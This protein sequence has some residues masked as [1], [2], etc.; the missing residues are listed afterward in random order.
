[1]NHL[2]FSSLFP[3]KL[4]LVQMAAALGCVAQ[5]HADDHM[6]GDIEEIVVVGTTPM[7]GVGINADL[8]PS[9]VQRVSAKDLE[10]SQA[11]SLAEHLRYNL[12]SVTINEA[13]NNA[14]QPDVQYRGFTA[15]PLLGLPQGMSLYLNGV[16]FNEPFGDTVNWDLL[17]TDAIASMDL[18]SGSNP[19]F[20]QNTLGGALAVKLK[21]GFSYSGNEVELGAGQFGYRQMQLQSGRSFAM[22]E[23]SDEQWGYYVIANKEEED[24]WRDS[25]GSEI[26]Q[27]LSVLSWKNAE[28]QV[29]FTALLDD[30]QMIGNGAVPMA[31]M[32]IEGREAIYTHP[33]QTENRLNYFAID[34]EHW[35]SDT[36]QIA[37]NVYVRSNTTNTL[38]GDDSDYEECDVGAFET[39]CEG[40]EGEEED[41]GGAEMEGELEPVHFLGYDEDETLDEI[42]DATGQDLEAD[43]LDGTVNTSK[44][45]Q[46]SMGFALQASVSDYLAGY[47]NLMVV[48]VSM[49]RADIEFRSRTEFAELRN[50]NPGDDRGA[51]GVGLYDAESEVQ[52]DTEVQNIGVFFTDTI[53]LDDQL[54]VT[55]GG[56]YSKTDVE[57]KDLIEEGEGSLNGDHT[58]S[59]F[60]PMAGATYAFDD[61]MT[62]YAS[63]SEASRAPTPAELSC[64]DED[65][66]CKLP[67]GFVSDPPLE[68][69]VTKSIEAGLRGQL[70]SD[71]SEWRWHAGVFRSINHDDILFQQ[72]GGLPSEGYFANVG[73]TKRLGTELTLSGG[74]DAVRVAAAYTWMKATFETPFISF[75]PNNPMGANRQVEKGDNIPGLPDHILKLAADW[76]VMNQVSIGADVQYRGSQYF[77]GDEANDNEQLDAYSIVNVR[78]AYQPTQQV[79]V[80]ARVANVFDKEYETFGVYGE[81]DEVLESVYDDFEEDSFVGP[82]APRTFKAGLKVAF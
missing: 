66:P 70:A 30:N 26:K 48:G 14:Y 12:G 44:T 17:P 38:N 5:V 59:R 80:Y 76:Q 49:D 8:L 54:S 43:D 9:Q 50:S 34:A 1:M 79:E 18:F 78:A 68:Q 21:D 27:L 75:S 3:K 2:P 62:G 71:A 32:D 65:D 23:A 33:D 16:R 82:G 45:R 64:A 74:W 53:Q 24:G 35:V 67:N 46:K 51:E 77:R 72:A 20:G 69:V 47:D 19:V 13:V 39:L 40:E 55:V 36:V 60:N 56:R 52:L 61:T 10:Q 58:F 81:A 31:L 37:G 7:S 73:K 15:S 42:A 63:Y 29:N 22:D 41:E 25:S 57:M 11:L 28:S 4:L 6:D